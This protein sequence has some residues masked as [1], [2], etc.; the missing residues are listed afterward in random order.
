MSD[1]FDPERPRGI[2]SE[3]DRQWLVADQ[4]E[5]K[6]Q[7]SRQAHYKRRQAIRERLRNGLLD[8]VLLADELDEDGVKYFLGEEWLS[9]HPEA[10]PVASQI[11]AKQMEQIEN[12]LRNMA[13]Q[14]GR[15]ADTIA[16]V[17]PDE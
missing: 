6:E 15:A 4:V 16:Q 2:L 11:H 5:R 12:R 8:L 3:V 13:E 7:F 14:L 9:E 17:T 10:R 1:R